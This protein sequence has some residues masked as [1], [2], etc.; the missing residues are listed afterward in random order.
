MRVCGC[1][2]ERER[3]RHTE[4]GECVCVKERYTECKRECVRD[5]E[6]E[7]YRMKVCVCE[8]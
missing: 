7:T 5:G 1:V 2:C 4:C 6:R 3:E 8:K